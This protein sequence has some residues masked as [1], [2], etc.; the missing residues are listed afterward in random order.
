MKKLLGSALLLTLF[1]LINGCEDQAVK[2]AWR[3]INIKIDGS[4]LDWDNNV[5]YSPD[6]GISMGLM[7][8]SQNV[9]LCLNI[10]NPFAIER[11]LKTGFIVW[12]NS[13]AD[14]DTVGVEYPIGIAPH[15]PFKRKSDSTE[16]NSKDTTKT[17]DTLTMHIRLEDLVKRQIKYNIINEDKTIVESDSAGSEHPVE[18]AISYRAGQLVYELRM[19]LLKNGSA[20]Y[21]INASPGQMINVG[22]QVGGKIR[23]MPYNF[24]GEDYGEPNENRGYNNGYGYRPETQRVQH[25]SL[26][27]WM[28]VLLASKDNL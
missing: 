28:K 16:D 23:N 2:S 14:S 13:A 27:T 6:L 4:Q 12:F 20:P 22:F 19:P 9:Y 26:S 21:A 15:E 24:E 5:N 18:T 10:K 17:K 11:I 25:R 3:S 7:N 8:D 1:V